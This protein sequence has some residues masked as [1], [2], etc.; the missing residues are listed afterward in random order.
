MGFILISLSHENPTFFSA[1]IRRTVSCI[2]VYYPMT[3]NNKIFFKY[4]DSVSNLNVNLAPV[5]LF[6]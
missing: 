4:R 5:L 6:F 3:I 2:I 1:N